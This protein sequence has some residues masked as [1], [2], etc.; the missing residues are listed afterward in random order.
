MGE[1]KNK[2]PHCVDD[3][4]TCDYYNYQKDECEAVGKL[5]GCDFCRNAFT[6]HRLQVEG[7]DGYACD[8]S[9]CVIGRG[10]KELLVNG[11]LNSSSNY[12]A[13]VNITVMKYY[14]A[15][16]KMHDI[17]KYVPKYC[18]ECG[19]FLKENKR[20]FEMQAEKEKR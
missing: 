3:C 18:P 1:T 12:K 2:Y 8:S 9:S 14:E 10:G 4:L 19:R 17:W 13:P 6:D 20:W 16:G 7:P 5:T 11:Y 15:D